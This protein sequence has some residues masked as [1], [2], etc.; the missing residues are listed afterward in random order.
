MNGGMNGQHN[1]HVAQLPRNMNMNGVFVPSR[2]L[3]PLATAIVLMVGLQGKALFQVLQHTVTASSSFSGNLNTL[4]PSQQQVRYTPSSSL[5]PTGMVGQHSNDNNINSLRGVHDDDSTCRWYLA[6]SAI[7]H[8]GLGVFTGIGLHKGDM[9]GFPDICIF[10]SDAPVKWTH[11]RSHSWGGGTFF[12]QYEGENSRAACEGFT[13]TYNTMP[14]SMLNTVLVSPVLQTNAGLHRATSPGAGAI[15]HHFGIHGKALD[16]ITAGSELTVDYGDWDFDEDKEYVKPVRDVT[17]L[18]KHGWCIDNIEIG[19]SS[20]PHAGR[21]AFARVPLKR[22]EVV[23]PAPLQAFKNRKVFQ[24][25]VPEQLYV[26]YGLQ[27]AGSKM[28]FF[29]YGAAVNL[30]NHSSKSP[31]VEWRWST[32]KSHSSV[33]HSSWLDLSY[34]DFW[35]VATPGGL[36]LEVV[37]LRDIQPGEELLLDYGKSWEE[38]WKAHMAKWKPPANADKYVYPAEMDETAF[39]RT[40]KEQETDPY[41]TNLATMCTTSDWDRADGNRVVWSPPSGRSWWERMTYCHILDRALDAATGDFRY[42]VS[43]VFSTDPKDLAYDPTVPMK[44]RLIDTKVPRR[45]IRF[46]EIPYMDDEHL[47]EAFRHPIEL[48]EHLVP[49]AWKNA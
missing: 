46:I 23:A 12:G 31:N 33:H 28:M 35:G 29:P 49:E 21:G 30:I 47:P 26:N 7:P 48:P 39:L 3:L 16:V 20:I 43:L 38:A 41:P 44:D 42:T 22:G 13:T 14:R 11:L 36:I 45:A 17:W 2:I 27:P 34:A 8:G 24:K 6:E 10:V 4:Q 1:N 5:Q 18:Q 15:T 19:V 40:V 9:V 32:Q 37:A 25:T